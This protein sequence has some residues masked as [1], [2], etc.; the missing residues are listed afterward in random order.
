MA[1]DKS[2]ITTAL[3]LPDYKIVK[4]F[5]VLRGIKESFLTMNITMKSFTSIFL[6]LI[7]F[8]TFASQIESQERA[9]APY[10]E[11]IPIKK[12]IERIS[13]WLQSQKSLQC[14]DE[15]KM[16]E[17]ISD[18]DEHVR[19]YETSVVLF[20]KAPAIERP[21]EIVPS[22]S[23]FSRDDP[24]FVTWGLTIALKFPDGGSAKYDIPLHDNIIFAQGRI[25]AI[26][27]SENKIVDSFLRELEKRS[28]EHPFIEEIFIDENSELFNEPWLIWMLSLYYRPDPKS[29]L[30]FDR[31]LDERY[32]G[33][34]EYPWIMA[35]EKGDGNAYPSVQ[36]N[37]SLYSQLKK[38]LSSF[39][40]KSSP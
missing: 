11:R 19:K 23:G 9:I 35:P 36:E 15:G 22:A 18:I 29:V 8:G 38:I 25:F 33:E 37:A 7:C 12:P 4:T 34:K 6:L 21:T 32:G 13:K 28:A 39:L 30:T 14:F 3:E 26:V 31:E 17:I 10:K 1:L 40:T 5:G 2:M 24:N 20:K 16:S 27:K